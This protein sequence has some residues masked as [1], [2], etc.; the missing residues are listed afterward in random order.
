MQ[1]LR[2]PLPCLLQ[3]WLLGRLW[4]LLNMPLTGTESMWVDPGVAGCCISSCCASGCLLSSR[5]TRTLGGCQR[6]SGCCR[7]L[8]FWT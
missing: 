2:R 3:L 1:L 5:H 4:D 8:V 7:N 6:C